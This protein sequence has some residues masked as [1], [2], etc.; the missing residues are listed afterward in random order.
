MSVCA[1]VRRRI[2]LP[3]PETGFASDIRR[4]VTRSYQMSDNARRVTSRW[5][6]DSAT[7]GT[8]ARRDGGL[9]CGTRISGKHVQ[10]SGVECELLP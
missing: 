2:S 8:G 1:S 10:T 6:A 3:R 9:R 5:H 7:A 4:P